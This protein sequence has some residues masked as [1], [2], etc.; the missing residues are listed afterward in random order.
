MIVIGVDV[1]GTFTDIVMLN[2]ETGE[3]NIH[4]VPS[5][6]QYQEQ[7]V[8]RGLNEILDRCGVDPQQVSSIVHG[9]TVATNA[10]LERTGARVC[11]ITTKGFE[12]VLEIGRQNRSDI[13]NVFAERPKPLVAR[14]DRIGIKERLDW[15]G[16]AIEPLT[17]EEISR[18]TNVLDELEPEAIAIS[19]LFSYKNPVHE[20]QILQAISGNTSC[21]IVASSDVLPEFREYERTSTTVL[22]AYL[23][24]LVLEYLAK[25]D[26]SISGVCPKARLN[27]MQSNGGTSLCSRLSG[28]AMALAISGLA[29]G[30][31]GGWHIAQSAGVS[32]ALTLDM[33][34]TSCDISAVVDSIVVRPDNE[35]AGLPLRF[36]SVDVKTIGAGGGSKAWI[37]DA[38]VLHVGPQSAGANPGPASYGFGGRIATVTDATLLLGRLNPDFFVGGEIKLQ[39][40]LAEKAIQEL[41]EKLALSIEETAAGIIRIST[42]N[43]VQAIREVTIERGRDPR[44]FVLVAFGGAGPTQGVDIARSL[45][46]EPILIPR[47][48]GITSA[49]GLL[50]ADLRVDLMKSIVLAAESSNLDLLRS[51]SDELVEEAKTRLLEQGANDT[52]IEIRRQVDM[53]YIGQSHELSVDLHAASADI[54][55]QSMQDFAAKHHMRYGY[56]LPDREMEWV[57]VRVTAT[58]PQL[59]K[60]PSVEQVPSKPEEVSQREVVLADGSRTAADV[61]RRESIPEGVKIH[62][63]AVIEQLDT[64]TWIDREWYALRDLSGVLWL[65]R[66]KHD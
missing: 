22:E 48:P 1:G 14:P 49:F 25:L 42:S 46:I 4:K 59:N 66:E 7:A 28:R 51:V 56:N 16:E 64:T 39:P 41:A 53:R 44:D 40:N 55:S 63:P 27:V 21:Y 15:Q 12:D 30:A 50:C 36:P 43:M 45:G 18:A 35:V 8:L 33:G 47:F 3:Q 10:M 34:G 37:D 23:G 19:F 62:G 20:K 65:R 31:I 58:A 9:T 13:Y 32:K 52:D 6:P 11:L 26:A 54:L 61:F 57:T 2:A 17:G 60:T 5:T 24:P 38:R 29:G